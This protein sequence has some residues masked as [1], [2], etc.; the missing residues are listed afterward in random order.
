MS[1][2]SP[3][4]PTLRAL[5]EAAERLLAKFPKGAEREQTPDS[6]VAAPAD[7]VDAMYDHAM[8][9]HDLLGQIGDEI[10]RLDYLVGGDAAA[11]E[12]F[13]SVGRIE[14]ILNHTRGNLDEVLAWRDDPKSKLVRGLLADMHRHL[15]DQI[16]GGS[17]GNGGSAARTRGHVG[18]TRASNH[19]QGNVALELRIHGPSAACCA[20]G[21][22]ETPSTA[23][24]EIGWF[25]G[26]LECSVVGGVAG[27]VAGRMTAERAGS[28]RATSLGPVPG[29]GLPGSPRF[30]RG[31]TM[32][33]GG[34]CAGS[35]AGNAARLAR[36]GNLA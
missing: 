14:V 6:S 24:R 4:S 18:K 17:K 27:L 31:G 25:V 36:P 28:R 26:L 1:D 21:L 33:G 22:G 32:S 5:C 3:L 20:G 16:R 11:A 29:A 19:R 34:I 15:F 35:S 13:S 23:W 12:V 10:T 8:R 9:Y 7:L 30:Q 2:D